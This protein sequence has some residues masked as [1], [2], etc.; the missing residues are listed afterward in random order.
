MC[1]ASCSARSCERKQISEN[2]LFTRLDGNCVCIYLP[3]HLM[4]IRYSK[5]IKQRTKSSIIRLFQI[6]RKIYNFKPKS[7][8]FTSVNSDSS[9]TV[10]MLCFLLYS[11]IYRAPNLLNNHKRF[12]LS[13]FMYHIFRSHCFKTFRSSP[14]LSIHIRGIDS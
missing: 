10:H 7:L 8:N 9:G 11:A 13:S 1:S 12:Q 6:S 14:S 4:W 3:L 2:G 5:D